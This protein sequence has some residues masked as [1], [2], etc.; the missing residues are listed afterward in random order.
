MMG[1]SARPSRTVVAA[2]AAAT[3][4]LAA[5]GGG[6]ASDAPSDSSGG[7]AAPAPADDGI[8]APL[9]DG[10]PN[11]SV[12]ILVIDEP[13]SYDALYIRDLVEAAQPFSPVEFK[14]LIRDNFGSFGTYEAIQWMQGEPGG[15][16]GYVLSMAKEPGISTDLIGEPIVAELDADLDWMQYIIGTEQSPLVLYT[17]NDRPWGSSFEDFVAYAKENKL[18]YSGGGGGSG[19]DIGMGSIAQVGGFEYEEIAGGNRTEIAAGVIAGL[20]D[21]AIVETAEIIQFVQDGRITVL[22][23]TQEG[24]P[25]VDFGSP[26]RTYEVLGGEPDVWGTTSGL[27]A[28]ETVSPERIQWFYD[29]FSRAAASE[30]FKAKRTQMVPGIRHLEGFDGAAYRAFAEKGYIAAYRSMRAAGTVAP[31]AE[32]P[33]IPVD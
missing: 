20:A 32:T 15:T 2:L 30:E 17:A 4:L 19:R 10:F 29:L 12:T 21:F 16:E 33:L 5:C 27:F 25:L 8:L 22:A 24:D 9:P 11:Q 18:V 1:G 3:L 28:P 26:P 13:G 14:I 6:S 23:A 7:T 31:G